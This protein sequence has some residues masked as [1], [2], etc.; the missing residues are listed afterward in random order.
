MQ[1]IWGSGLSKGLN[2]W[3][4]SEFLRIKKVEKS[5]SGDGGIEV[6]GEAGGLVADGGEGGDNKL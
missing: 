5:G 3:S 2:D 6:L 1:M 4:E